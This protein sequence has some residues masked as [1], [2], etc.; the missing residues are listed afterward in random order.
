MHV[1]INIRARINIRNHANIGGCVYTG[2]CVHARCH[3]I[4]RVRGLYSR[5]EFEV[6]LEPII[7]TGSSRHPTLNLPPVQF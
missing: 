3:S 7:R 1:N 6:I 4:T 2:N 5:L